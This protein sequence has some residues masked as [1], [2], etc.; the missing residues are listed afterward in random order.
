MLRD[1]APN[2]YKQLLAAPALL[3]IP[4]GPNNPLQTTLD[5][6]DRFTFALATDEKNIHLKSWTTPYACATSLP[7]SL[8]MG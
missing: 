7:G 4:M 5:K 3:G 8:R 6:I 1:K 2:A